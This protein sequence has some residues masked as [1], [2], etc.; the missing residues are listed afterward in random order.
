MS[1]N[2][3]G[4]CSIIWNKTAYHPPRT[5][6]AHILVRFFGPLNVEVVVEELQSVNTSVDWNIIIMIFRR[7]IISLVQGRIWFTCCSQIQKLADRSDVIFEVP[8]C[9]KMQIFRGS[10]P[11]PAGEAYSPSPDGEGLTA[12]FPRTQPHSRPFGPP[13]YRSQGLT[14]CRIGNPTNDTFQ[15]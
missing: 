7:W 8:K 2:Y 1:G 15:M 5:V 6:V 3:L 9:S 11:D 14:H 12:P 13:F 4:C 10:A